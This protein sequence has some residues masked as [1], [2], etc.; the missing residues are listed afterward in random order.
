MRGLMT[1]TWGWDCLIRDASSLEERRED[2]GVL[3]C[4][5]SCETSKEIFLPFCSALW[6][7]VIWCLVAIVCE[8]NRIF[9]RTINLQIENVEVHV[10]IKYAFFVLQMRRRLMFVA[11][12]SV[13]KTWKWCASGI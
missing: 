3:R 6:F 4:Y 2:L 13:G 1:M 12:F 8:A 9:S 5:S 10:C 11:L 7:V